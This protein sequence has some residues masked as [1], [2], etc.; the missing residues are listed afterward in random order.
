[1]DR[2]EEILRAL[3]DNNQEGKFIYLGPGR[4]ED[5]HWVTGWGDERLSGWVFD[6]E[7]RLLDEKSGFGHKGQLRAYIMVEGPREPTCPREPTFQE[8]L[9]ALLEK[10]E[11]RLKAESDRLLLVVN[12]K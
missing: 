5:L 12:N 1:M 6:A 7:A 8:C 9:T 3:D 11:E 2:L 10:A 4:K